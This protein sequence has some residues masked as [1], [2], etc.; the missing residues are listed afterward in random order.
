MKKW[1]DIIA[2]RVLTVSGF[3]TSIVIVLIIAFLFAEAVGL[4]SQPRKRKIQYPA[5]RP[6]R[7]RR[8]KYFSIGS[9][10]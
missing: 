9:V 8:S 2:K 7:S 6:A 4:F 1:I 10:T 3:V 5:P